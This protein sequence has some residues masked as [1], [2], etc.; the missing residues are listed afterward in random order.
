[1]SDVLG[2]LDESEAGELVNLRAWY[3]G[4][5]AEVKTVERLDR[6]KAGDPRKHVAGPGAARVTFGP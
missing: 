6:R 2:A 3:T 4:G 1:M 5:E